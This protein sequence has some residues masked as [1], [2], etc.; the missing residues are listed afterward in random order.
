M[1]LPRFRVS[2][3]IRSSS[4]VKFGGLD[5]TEGAK[6]G[7]I[8]DMKNLSSKDYPVLSTRFPRALYGEISEPNGF[9]S[10]DGLYWVSGDTF[11]YKGLPRGD[12]TPGAKTFATLGAYIIIMPD[13]AYYNVL[14]GDFGSLE[15][16]YVGA[17][18]T[19][20]F[21]NGN[22][23]GVPADNNAITTTGAPFPFSIGDSISI[24]G[25][26]TIP[27]NNRAAI[28]VQGL[29]ANKRTLYFYPNVFYIPEGARPFPIAE[30]L[31]MKRSVPD[32]DFMC[33]NNNRLWGCKEDSIFAS[34]L[35][36]IFDWTSLSAESDTNA[37][38]AQVGSESDFTGCVSYRG[39]PMFFKEDDVY[40]VYGDLPSNFTIQRTATIGVMDGSSKSIAVAGETLFYLSRTGVMAFDGGRPV[41]LSAPFGNERYRDGVAGTDGLKYYISMTDTSGARRLYV[42]DTQRGVWHAEDE[43]DARDFAFFDENLYMLTGAGHILMVGHVVTAPMGAVTEAPFGWF[44]EFGDFVEDSAFKKTMPKLLIRCELAEGAWCDVLVQYD[45]SG[46]WVPFA[47]LDGTVKQSFYLP[48]IPRRSDHYRL[49]FVG[50][51]D[52]KLHSLTR[53]YAGGSANRSHKL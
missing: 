46:E 24:E 42:Y 16:E 50:M 44:C 7:A 51:G 29:S 11:Y 15:A 3:G 23:Q 43:S 38:Q 21:G 19:F 14:T 31:T 35:G 47:H 53:E 4:A 41:P 40:R 2:D 17:A 36:S 9:G 27:A 6:D 30:A 26:T 49:K 1:K 10:W 37:W 39:T 45:S 34:G 52:F 18:G 25:N 12:V 32:M 28:V 8:F 22:Y 13:K 48:L 33:E 5:H 20:S